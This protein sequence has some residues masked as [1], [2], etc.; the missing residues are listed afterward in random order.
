MFAHFVCRIA[1]ILFNFK[2]G[3]YA[4]ADFCEQAKI[5][6][7]LKLLCMNNEYITK[8]YASKFFV[9]N[10]QFDAVLN[11]MYIIVPFED[12]RKEISLYTSH[13]CLLEITILYL[14][15]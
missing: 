4:L 7:Y 13:L 6:Q 12:V 9:Y 5:I 3:F 11:I 2:S 8:N 1:Y 15:I 10:A 14:V